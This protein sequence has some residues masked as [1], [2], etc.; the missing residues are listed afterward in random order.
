[1][2]QRSFEKHRL[3]CLVMAVVITFTMTCAAV[4]TAN[5]L[6][7]TQHTSGDYT[8]ILLDDG[9]AEITGCTNITTDLTIPS[10][11]DGIS[12]TSIGENAFED[13]GT[14]VNL[15]ISEGVKNVGQN[16]FAGN[17]FEDDNKSVLTSVK[18]P[19]S[20]E[21]IGN[22]AFRSNY[23]LSSINFPAS[24]TS[25]GNNAFGMCNSLT[26]V[27][28]HR[29][30]SLK[31]N[32]FQ[33]CKSLTSVTLPSDLTSVPDSTF[34]GCS[35]LTS[36]DIPDSVKT[37]EQ[38]AFGHCTSLESVVI[39]EGVEL[40][41]N[42]AFYNCGLTSITIPSTVKE[43]KMGAFKNCMSLMEVTVPPT[44][45]TIG[46]MAFGYWWNGDPQVW[47]DLLIEGFVLKGCDGS[48]ADA[49]CKQYGVAYESL[50]E[51]EILKVTLASQQ[52]DGYIELST[53]TKYGKAPVK[54]SYSA[55]GT[56]IE[57]SSSSIHWTPSADG[58]YVI[59]CT[60]TDAA[61]ATASDSV[62]LYIKN[63]VIGEPDPLE[64]YTVYFDNS[65]KNFATPYCYYWPKGGRSPVDWPGKPMELVSGNI[66]KF[67]FPAENNMCIFNGNGSGQTGDLE[68][69]GN[70]YLYDGSKWSDT[71]YI[72]PVDPPTTV[73]P[74]T[75]PPTTEPAKDIT[76]YFDNT[77]S[78]YSQ[79][80]AMYWPSDGRSVLEYPGVKMEPV[81]GNIYK[82]TYSSVNDVIMFSDNGSSASDVVTIP[83]DSY[84][85][86]GSEWSSEPF[87]PSI[88]PYELGD[89]NLDGVVDICD[90]TLIQKHL[91]DSEQ[92]DSTQ[93]KIADV[94]GDGNISI[95]DVTIIQKYIA[96][97]VSSLSNA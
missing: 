16:A 62:T 47:K 67:T 33:D 36:I 27:N 19:E 23:K 38:N 85:Y 48:A 50:G 55:N 76:V 87:D 17:I 51:A 46:D 37:I 84:L 44:V 69:P 78:A 3:L 58:E 75:I 81:Y 59:S 86:N 22:Y 52:M 77:V 9:T 70:N 34:F 97:L 73:P 82:C 95:D 6:E 61:G 68:L 79:P 88:V 56:P 43:I 31:K 41:A 96:E 1:M 57:G 66:Y 30:I 5:A 8:Y 13:N 89:V 53:T 7:P 91:V 60:A 11:L 14:L 93:L 39:S 2:I 92:F 32:V 26:S 45:T 71:P 25:I 64:F 15:V 20:L 49:Y 72:T 42:G 54:L 29:G 35:A 74:T 4:L 90:A 80:Y 21:T 65:T 83:G 18:L 40:I 24:L 94:T 12:V 10:T 28:L 63:G